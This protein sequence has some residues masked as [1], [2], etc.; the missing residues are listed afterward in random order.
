MD[1]VSNKFQQWQEFFK[2]TSK[3]VA[4]VVDNGASTSKAGTTTNFA[5]NEVAE[6]VERETAGSSAHLAGLGCRV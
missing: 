4:G 1:Q 2:L 3:V 6:G 5:T